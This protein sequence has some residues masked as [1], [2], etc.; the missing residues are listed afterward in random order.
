ML[1][2]GEKN[3]NNICNLKVTSSYSSGSRVVEHSLNITKINGLSQS[4]TRFSGRKEMAKLSLQSY[5]QE[6]RG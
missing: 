6:Q 5:L 1:A 2:P 4:T 3:G